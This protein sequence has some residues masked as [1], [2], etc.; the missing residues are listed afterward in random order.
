MK[1][2]YTLEEIEHWKQMIPSEYLRG[3]DLIDGDETWTIKAVK[4]STVFKSGNKEKLKP[5]ISFV[6]TDKIWGPSVTAFTTIAGLY[7]KRPVEWIGKRVT[8][9]AEDG[10][11]NPTDGKTGL[12]VRVRPVVPAAARTVAAKPPA[13]S[14][15]PDGWIL[16]CQND[17]TLAQL[18]KDKKLGKAAC[19]SAWVNAGADVDKFRC[20]VAGM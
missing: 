14:I 16:A 17:V 5:S 3:V 8:L 13:P 2:E 9:F 20:D 4:V 19:A 7:G 6:E 18:V 12:G 11:R 1:R 15:A 10:V